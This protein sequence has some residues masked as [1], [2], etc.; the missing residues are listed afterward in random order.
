[1]KYKIGDKVKIKSREWWDAQPKNKYGSVQ[2]GA[3]YFTSEMTEICGRE[4]EIEKVFPCFNKYWIK[5]FSCLWTDEMFEDTEQSEKEETKQEDKQHIL[6]EELVKDIADIIN[7]HNL[8]VKIEERDGGLLVKPIEK[9][10]DLPID[11]PC[12]VCNKPSG[13]WYLRYYAGYKK[14]F[15]DS[16]KSRDNEISVKWKFIIPFNKFDPNNIEESLK[17]NIVK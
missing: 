8:S 6:S 9:E 11:T 16:K 4:V 3:D 5:E 10:N 1:M 14:T 12:M 15:I 17:Y 7:K 2:C 13:D